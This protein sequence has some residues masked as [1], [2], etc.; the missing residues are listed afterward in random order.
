MLER[1]CSSVMNT[2]TETKYC[3]KNNLTCKSDPLHPR[4]E[5]FEFIPTSR[6]SWLKLLQNNSW[7]T[8]LKGFPAC[9]VYIKF[10]KTYS[11]Y[12]IP[13]LQIPLPSPSRSATRGK[14][15]L[16]YDCYSR[17]AI[18]NLSRHDIA[19]KSSWLQ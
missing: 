8:R 9:L 17:I 16:W 4:R 1:E 12:I 14:N 13:P 3:F 10:S 6:L 7:S 5:L 15:S 18:T 19:A 11:A 2:D